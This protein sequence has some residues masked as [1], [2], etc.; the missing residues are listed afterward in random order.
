MTVLGLGW[1]LVWLVV[2]ADCFEDGLHASADIVEF[3]LGDVLDAADVAAAEVVDDGVKAIAGVVVR[4]GVDL[5]AGFGADAA[6]LVV[7]VGEGNA[8]DLLCRNRVG[9]AR[10]GLYGALVNGDVGGDAVVEE[11]SAEGGVGVG[12]EADRGDGAHLGGVGGVAGVKVEGADVAV[13]AG[14]V[15]GWRNGEGDAV[16]GVVEGTCRRVGRFGRG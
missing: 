8:G 13:S 14:D 15:P 16:A 9:S 4:G 6:V 1:R 7:A 3:A 2:E 5:V 11:G 10:D 12:I